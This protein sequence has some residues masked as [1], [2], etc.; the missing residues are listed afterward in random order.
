MVSWSPRVLGLR[1]HPNADKI[2]LVDV[3]SGDGEPLQIVCGAFNM[4]VGDL[5]PLAT[6]GTVMPNGMK[7]ERRKMRGEVSNGM[8]CSASELGFGD[9][10]SGIMIL[11]PDAVPGTHL[12]DAL[13]IEVDVLYDLEVNPNRPDAMSVAGVARDLAARLGVPFTLPTIEVPEAAGG[14]AASLCVRRD[15]RSAT[16]AV[17]SLLACCAGS[18]SANRHRGSLVGY[19]RWVCVRSTAWSTCRTT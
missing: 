15:R 9:D 14:D 5:V 4:A 11:P 13:G 17:D 12:R 7:I 3:D 18:R 10:H 16:C 8:L 6:T 1:P 19:E 2:Q